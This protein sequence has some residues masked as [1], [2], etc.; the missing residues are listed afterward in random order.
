MPY[1]DTQVLVQ[2]GS[3]IQG[4][5]SDYS[6]WRIITAAIGGRKLIS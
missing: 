1:G 5:R 6:K 4:T 3:S 2:S